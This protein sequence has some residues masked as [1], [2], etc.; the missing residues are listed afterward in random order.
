MSIITLILLLNSAQLCIKIVS[1][2][3]IKFID[4]MIHLIFVTNIY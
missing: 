1:L 2:Q 4:N 3:I